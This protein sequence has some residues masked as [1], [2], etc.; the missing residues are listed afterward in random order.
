MA[1]PLFFPAMRAVAGQGFLDQVIQL[2][3]ALNQL[4]QHRSKT[5]GLAH[6]TADKERI[7]LPAD[8][9]RLSGAMLGARR[10]VDAALLI[11]PVMVLPCTV[12]ARLVTHNRFGGTE[13]KTELAIAARRGNPVRLYGT[14][15]TNIIFV[16]LG[17]V[18]GATRY[19]HLEFRW[20]LLIKKT[21]VKL[22]C[23]LL[24]I[25]DS[26]FTGRLSRTGNNNPYPR[27]GST[28][29]NSR[30]TQGK[31]CTLQIIMMHMMNLNPLTG[32]EM[33]HSPAILFS[34]FSNAAKLHGTQITSNCLDAQEIIIV[35][36]LT[37]HTR[38]SHSRQN[39]F[40][41]RHAFKN[42][43]DVTPFTIPVTCKKEDT[44]QI[45]DC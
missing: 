20:S 29:F 7:A 6:R 13:R 42:F 23:N 16:C 19:R 14:P 31:L 15:D 45:N 24:G 5:G 21:T 33:N 28:H 9:P 11:N 2:L 35:L 17:T 41:F 38:A 1:K 4:L 18:I 44:A 8:N 25:H 27:A 26:P 37:Q 39:K 3:L 40:T 32:R 36:L 30:L 22:C 43:G 10:A 12:G 34:N